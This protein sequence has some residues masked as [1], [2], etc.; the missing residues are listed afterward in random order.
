MKVEIAQKWV[1]AL[2]SGEF[3]QGQYVLRSGDSF[4]CLGVL[5]ELHRREAGGEWVD[6]DGGAPI[7]RASL[8]LGFDTGLPREVMDWAGVHSANG[9]F[10]GDA[11][12]LAI[13]NDNGGAFFEIADLIEE[14]MDG[15]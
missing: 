4:C 6:D 12:T 8:Y 14:K 2:R 15:L 13:I 10:F 9:A 11:R 7:D 5:C 1:A 3:Q